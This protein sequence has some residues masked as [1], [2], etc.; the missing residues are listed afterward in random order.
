MKKIQV[1][2]ISRLREQFECYKYEV[3][4]YWDQDH[5]SKANVDEMSSNE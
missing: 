3:M 5:K 1:E 2:V 4:I